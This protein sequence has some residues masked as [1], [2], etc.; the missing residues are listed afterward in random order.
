[1]KKLV[2][3]LSIL[4]FI[5]CGHK[6]TKSNLDTVYIVSYVGS[7]GDTSTKGVFVSP[8]SDFNGDEDTIA[9]TTQR[10]GEPLNIDNVKLLK[11]YNQNDSLFKERLRAGKFVIDYG[12]LQTTYI[13]GLLPTGRYNTYKDTVSNVDSYIIDSTSVTITLR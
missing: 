3:F 9:Y 5:S 13:I 4:T 1:M 10:L 11:L 8:C 2:L 7:H 6:T 12:E